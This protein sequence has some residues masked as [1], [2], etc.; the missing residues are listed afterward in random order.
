MGCIDSKDYNPGGACH[1]LER[2]FVKALPAA[3]HPILS[4]IDALDWE[5]LTESGF[6]ESEYGKLCVRKITFDGIEAH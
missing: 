5:F 6:S 2:G 4:G 1:K 3:D